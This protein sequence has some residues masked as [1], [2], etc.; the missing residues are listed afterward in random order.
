M[1]DGSERIPIQPYQP[2]NGTEGEWFTSQFCERCVKDCA[3][4]RC[5][6]P[7]PVW[8]DGCQILARAY[9]YKIGDAK[10]PSEWVRIGDEPQCTAFVEDVGQ[11][12][13]PDA[14]VIELE[15]AGQRR[16]VP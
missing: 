1:S 13:P 15:A 16:L 8:E 4:N 11:K 10:Y 9:A 3:I 14:T 6:G 2:C 5:D 7:D 12:W